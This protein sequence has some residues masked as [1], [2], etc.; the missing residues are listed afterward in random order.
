[1]ALACG[2]RAPMLPYGSRKPAR[3]SPRVVVFL[4]HWLLIAHLLLTVK[5]ARPED[6][7]RPGSAAMTVR[8]SSIKAVNPSAWSVDIV[9][10]ILMAWSLPK[11]DKKHSKRTGLVVY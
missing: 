3:A 5:R 4:V 11:L 10:T 2:A 7:A 9:S 6:Q 1:M 8:I